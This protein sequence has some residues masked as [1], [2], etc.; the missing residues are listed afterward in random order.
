MSSSLEGFENLLFQNGRL[1]FKSHAK[2]DLRLKLKIY[3]MSAL[4][5]ALSGDL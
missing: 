2:T 1:A 3:V 4:L 5:Q